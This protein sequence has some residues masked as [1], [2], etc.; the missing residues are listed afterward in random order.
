MV[1]VLNEQSPLTLDTYHPQNRRRLS[2]D[3]KSFK[4]EHS[5]SHF[6]CPLNAIAM[7]LSEVSQH[8][9]PNRRSKVS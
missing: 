1:F 2:Q 6:P 4:E 3:N 8:Q 5:S 9:P 7:R